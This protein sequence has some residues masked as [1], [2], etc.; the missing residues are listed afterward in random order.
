MNYRRISALIIALL[1]SPVPASGINGI[2]IINARII[3]S[4][5]VMSMN[6]GYLEIENTNPHPVVLTS[7]SSDDFSN[8]EIHQTILE[9]GVARMKKAGPLT[10]PAQSRW[11]FKPGDYHLM[12]FKA[13]RTLHAGETTSLRFHF[14]DGLT[15]DADATITPVSG[16]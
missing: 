11:I 8:I 12:L 3:E 6:A 10:I 2:N 5:P 4:P 15:V 1:C 16:R 9:N 14:S 7:V 13:K